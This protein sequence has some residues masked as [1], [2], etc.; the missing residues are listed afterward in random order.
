M[1]AV[2]SPPSLP[3]VP[4]WLTTQPAS[5]LIRQ[6]S[7]V[8]GGQRWLD[9]GE[10]R[11]FG[12][13]GPSAE[14]NSS[15]PG[16]WVT[17]PT[18]PSGGSETQMADRVRAA[19][20]HAMVDHLAVDRAR[21]LD[22]FARLWREVKIDGLIALTYPVDAGSTAPDGGSIEGGGF[23]VDHRRMVEELLAATGGRVLTADL[24][25]HHPQSIADGTTWATLVLRRL[26]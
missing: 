18:G 2:D 24:V 17:A 15:M 12:W 4:P 6:A 1:S 26:R 11:W 10:L 5:D 13:G 19:G 25:V 8:L 14:L 3:T 23:P 9:E 16:R 22:W 20:V 7:S 21:R